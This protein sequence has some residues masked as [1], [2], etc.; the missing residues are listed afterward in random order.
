MDSIYRA[1]AA[2]WKSFQQLA[3]ALKDP[4]HCLLMP[5]GKVENQYDRLKL[6]SGN[7]GAL[8][9]GRAS[10]DFRLRESTVVRMNVLKLLNKLQQ[11]LTLSVEVAAGT[12]LPLEKL[13]L[14]NDS[15]DDESSA[16]DSD[17]EPLTELGLHMSTITEILADLYRLAFRIRSTATR[18]RS[19]KPLLYREVDEQTGIDVFAGFG[20]FDIRHVEDSFIQLR[21]E[22]AQK[23]SMDLSEAVK[24]TA[25]DRALIDR[26]GTTITQRRKFIR[27][28]QRHAQKLATVDSEVVPL[29]P[30]PTALKNLGRKLEMHGSTEG[31]KQFDAVPTHNTAKTTLL[32]ET[33][34]T[35]YDRK[36]DDM[37]ETQSFISYASTT[38][39]MHGEPVDVPPP[40][41]AANKSPE[42]LCPYCGIMCPSSHARGR[43]WKAHIFR[44]LQPYVCTYP[45]CPDGLQMY[46]TR[47]AWLEH[48]R[49]AHRRVWQCF[50]HQALLFNSKSDLRDHLESQHNNITGAQIE[51]FL[52]ISESSLKDPREKCPICLLERQFYQ[53][54]D[55]HLSFHLERFS[56]FST[57]GII[58]K[59]D[60]K[61]ESDIDN[62]SARPRARESIHSASFGPLS[63]ETTPRSVT[64]PLEEFALPAD[65]QPVL[66]SD[67]LPPTSQGSIE[68]G[69]KEIEDMKDEK[70]EDD[71]PERT[72]AYLVPI[73][74]NGG[75]IMS[76]KH[77]AAPH[78]VSISDESK[79]LARRPFSA[80]SY[81]I[82][83]HPE[84][85]LILKSATVSNR[86]CI[87]YCEEKSGA[88]VAFLQNLSS[89]GTFVNETFVRRN[90]RRQ[91][92]D[93]DEIAITLEYRFIIK[94]SRKSHTKSFSEKY[95]IIKPVARGNFATI[96]SCVEQ[97][98]GIMYAVKKLEKPNDALRLGMQR[99]IAALMT[100]R[101]PALLP[102]EEPFDEIDA[103]YLVMELAPEGDLFDQI[104]SRKKLTESETRI[105]C[106][107]LF[108][109]VK[110]LHERNII[111]RDIKPE[112]ILVFDKDLRIKLHV[113]LT[114]TVANS[115]TDMFGS[116][117]YAAPEILTRPSGTGPYTHA[118][119]IWSLGVVL[120]ICLCGFPP[121]S[122]ELYT[123]EFPYN[124]TQQILK[125]LFSYP[126]PYWDSVGDPVLDLIDKMLLVNPKDRLTIEGCLEHPWL[127][128]GDSSLPVITKS[129][130]ETM[131]DWR[132]TKLEAEQAGELSSASHQAKS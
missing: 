18:L 35:K 89:N 48:E 46:T 55:K 40:P 90:N 97:S 112:K 38:F 100:I 57:S 51:N 49:L 127:I 106:F 122:D 43:A 73:T 113:E 44:D 126:S 58:P 75:S 2:S 19:L 67:Y 114:M 45:A 131:E 93:G 15:S 1:T 12:R 37:L 102:L 62:Q 84:C 129:P 27:Y 13:S 65:I 79:P 21:R 7:L 32:S 115:A 117:G 70:I 22:A 26:L 120:Y 74:R 123:P 78:A 80:K 86:H 63:F 53:R 130:I 95:T 16:E 116:V 76:L 108:Q 121:F 85:D 39:D 30:T 25:E 111:H 92:A 6:W 110:Y 107:Q 132:P 87:I 101:H 105:V 23:M 52:E 56:T 81:L 42:F 36:L 31:P 68:V 82:G 109:G 72:W 20:Y 33:V 98:T 125:G 11:A 69:K 104:V 128:S 71:D 96:Y 14:P 64:P 103:L 8:Q 3:A 99:E 66:Q 41:S 91:L 47:H 94:Y 54:L 17:E 61:D 83:R 77:E 5:P 4:E 88:T 50:E 59:D 9:T 60:G 24:I 118:V 29:R 119:D 28:W 124:I 10:L 34:A